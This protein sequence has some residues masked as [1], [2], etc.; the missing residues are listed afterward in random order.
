[1]ESDLGWCVAAVAFILL[2]LVLWLWWR[3]ACV[4]N[5]SSSSSGSRAIKAMRLYQ[6]VNRIER[7][8]VERKISGPEMLLDVRVVS[9][10]DSLHYLGN[11]A[12]DRAIQTLKITSRDNVLD[13]GSGFGGPARHLA[14]TTQC[15]VV[16]IELQEDLHKVALSLTARCGLSGNVNHV[17]ADFMRSG[18]NA[19]KNEYDA[20]VS[21]LCFL[22][23][24]Q[25]EQLYARCFES[26]KP[27]GRIY[28]ED[29][30][31]QGSQFSAEEV[32]MLQYDVQASRLQTHVGL[33]L[34]LVFAGFVDIEISVCTDAWAK[35]VVA[36]ASAFDQNM[37]RNIRVH[38]KDMVTD[39]QHFY[40]V[41]QRYPFTSIF[42]FCARESA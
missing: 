22:H 1:M 21:W 42:V 39:M 35:F 20:I 40:H 26:L 24:P 25:K 14:Q 8:L 4:S 11:E 10:M 37:E 6:H 29:F 2:V 16:A 19:P 18:T 30:F 12:V 33:F 38:G 15:R 31:Q 9:E 41:M 27:G 5:H 36:R 28:I 13:I 34:S 32:A 23:I 17:C 3:C 7:E